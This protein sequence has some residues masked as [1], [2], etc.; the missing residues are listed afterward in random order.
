MSFLSF[1]KLRAIT[2]PERDH[3]R[4]TDEALRDVLLA[5]RLAAKTNNLDIDLIE[6]AT[7]TLLM[8]LSARQAI[9]KA[10]GT[11]RP[12]DTTGFVKLAREAIGAPRSDLH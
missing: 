2:D 7:I 3:L 9:E 6:R 12:L 4:Q 1:D 10:N 11:K 8:H 5:N